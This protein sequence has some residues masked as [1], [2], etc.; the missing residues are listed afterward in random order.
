VMAIAMMMPRGDRAFDAGMASMGIYYVLMLGATTFEMSR[1][2]EHAEARDWR[3]VLPVTD[4]AALMEGSA[5]ALLCGTIWPL[6]LGVGAVFVAVVG[7]PALGEVALAVPM[8]AAAVTFAA[9]PFLRVLPFT[10]GAKSSTNLDRLPRF[11]V[12]VL[13]MGFLIGL[14]GVARMHPASNALAALGALV[15]LWFGWR[16]LA[17]WG[18]GSRQA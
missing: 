11:I 7:L 18:P 8:T 14:H 13:A 17:R 12:L 10:A 6:L 15:L 16:R 9:R 5:K 3:R 2:S 4:P 1:L